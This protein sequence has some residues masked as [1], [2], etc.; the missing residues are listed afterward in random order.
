MQYRLPPAPFPV[1]SQQRP[2]ALEGILESNQSCTD[3]DRV[4]GVTE[5]APAARSSPFQCA[6]YH[7]RPQGRMPERMDPGTHWNQVQSQRVFIEHSYLS[8]M[9]AKLAQLVTV[10][11]LSELTS[12]DKGDHLPSSLYLTQPLSVTEEKRPRAK[13]TPGAVIRGGGVTEDSGAA[14][15]GR[16]GGVLGSNSV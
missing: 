15:C 16:P 4:P 8:H 11:V 13:R 12:G 9:W 2:V 6:L 3:G 5:R 7:P 10:R 14:C 1:L